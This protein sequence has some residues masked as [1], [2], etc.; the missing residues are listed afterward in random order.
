[1]K[2]I[3]YIAVAFA[4]FALSAW[5]A[6]PVVCA[7]TTSTSTASST[8][9]SSDGGTCSWGQG[10]NVLMQCTTDVYVNSQAHLPVG[11]FRTDGGGWYYDGGITGTAA[12]ALDQRVDFTSNT[13]PY[14]VYL[15]P[16]DQHVSLL[17]VTSAGSCKFM[18]TKR[19]KPGQAK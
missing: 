13:D 4:A 14:P 19:P 17:A 8:I 11:N 10:A 12:S 3:L 6:E 5:A 18:T 15:D 2:N 7:V 9:L 1:M 16:N